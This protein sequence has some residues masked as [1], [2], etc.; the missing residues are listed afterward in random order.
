MNAMRTHKI[1][2]PMRESTSA[3][4]LQPKNQGTTHHG[5]TESQGQSAPQTRCRRVRPG[6]S[7]Q[8]GHLQLQ[9][10]NVLGNGLGIISQTIHLVH[11]EGLALLRDDV[12]TLS[13]SGICGVLKGPLRGAIELEHFE[14]IEGEV[15]NLGRDRNV[16]VT[17]AFANVIGIEEGG[18]EGL[19]EGTT[20]GVLDE[21]KVLADV[22]VGDEGDGP[23][24]GTGLIV[25]S[26]I[27]KIPIRRR[28]HLAQVLR[29]G[30]DTGISR[31]L[32]RQE[33][34]ISIPESNLVQHRLVTVRRI[35][36]PD[37]TQVSLDALDHG[38]TS[39]ALVR[40]GVPLDLGVLFVLRPSVGILGLG[41]LGVEVMSD[42]IRGRGAQNA[43]SDVDGIILRDVE[44]R[45]DV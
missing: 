16:T 27:G 43:T 30:L 8:T 45:V 9:L 42:R 5:S 38:T 22:D 13:P 19:E 4:G 31:L 36:V 3:K 17:G 41:T 2:L 20:G 32:G 37:G 39:V 34:P 33:H 29:R 7:L 35:N 12:I 44:A 21:V 11:H 10:T 28:G 40:L 18:G 26:D 1:L 6:P 25:I 15:A 23:G 24:V 14:S